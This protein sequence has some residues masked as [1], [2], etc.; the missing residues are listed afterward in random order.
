MAISLQ[1]L[2]P[3]LLLVLAL[4]SLHGCGCGFDCN[5]NGSNNSGNPALLTL[6]LS[7]SLPEDLKKVVIQINS[8]TFRRS[9]ADDVVINTFTVPEQ[10]LTD[11]PSFQIDLLNYHGVK[12]LTV[13]E[14]LELASGN[15]SEVSIAINT[16]SIN[17]SYVQQD[18]DSLKAIKVSGGVLTLPGMKLSSGD[19]VFTIEFSLAQ[20][21]QFQAGDDNYLLTTNGMRIED[22]LTGATLSGQVES[23]LFNTVSPCS[24]KTTP[25]SGNRIY[26]YEGS[27][28]ARATLADVFT[29][30]SATTPPAA[31]H[32][33]FAVASLT[34]S[35][36]TGNWEYAFGYVPAGDYTLAF[37]CNTADD[38][39]VQY[40]GL[41]IPLPDNQ[42]YN[43]TLSE[44]DKSVCNL[45]TAANCE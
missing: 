18:D 29:S 36:Q 4:F 15:Y 39:S 31:A 19:Q 12:Q 32:A 1:L 28:L 34:E 10:G 6:G 2:L 16:D 5:S 20:A 3:A 44:A 42:V 41:Q 30:A 25:T 35:S 22:N 14:A 17:N 26:L 45:T 43:I 11:A 9:G 8:I 23:S 24:A 33:P 37:S 38:E 40:N 13:I 27:N 21:L 7:D